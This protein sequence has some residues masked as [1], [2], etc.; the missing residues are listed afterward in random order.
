MTLQLLICTIDGGID[1]VVDLILPPQPGI[2]YVVSWQHSTADGHRDVPAPLLRDDIQVFHL[3]GRGLS[4]NRNNCLRHASADVCLIGDDDCRYTVSGLQA[5]M[6]TFASHP[7]TDLATFVMQNPY[8]TKPYPTSAIDLRQRPRGYY[9]T[10]FEIAFR[11]QSVRGC[12]QFNEHFGLGAPL[13]H[14]CEEEIFVHDALSLGLRC[15]F[16][17][18]TI[19]EHDH[20]TTDAARATTAGVLMGKGAYLY[21]GYRSKML[22]YPWPIAWRLHKQHGV[23][24]GYG[25]RYLYWGLFHIMR[26]QQ[27]ATAG[28]I[29]TDRGVIK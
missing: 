14:C 28:V 26:H 3:E 9:P 20:P 6:D 17:P 1:N 19:V 29:A 4:R 8:C 2:G 7:D 13:F 12:L 23:S 18:I 5:V 25:L 21:I 10:S 16:Y 24:L 11:L 15:H 22:L 27:K